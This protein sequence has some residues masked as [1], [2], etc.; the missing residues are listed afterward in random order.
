MQSVSNL[1]AA[2]QAESCTLLQEAT[3]LRCKVDALQTEAEEA[4]SERDCLA[5]HCE[6]LA[7]Q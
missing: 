1:H 5:M 2:G 6:I 4:G 3:L 7:E